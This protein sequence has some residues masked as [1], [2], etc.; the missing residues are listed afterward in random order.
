MMHRLAIN[1]TV[2]LV[3]NAILEITCSESLR[4]DGCHTTISRRVGSEPA[5]SQ[6]F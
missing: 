5:A 2:R 6:S 4:K 3:S 1:P